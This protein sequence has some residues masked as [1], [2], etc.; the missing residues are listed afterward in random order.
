MEEHKIEKI[1][2]VKD[3]DSSSGSSGSESCSSEDS[4]SQEDIKFDKEVNQTIQIVDKDNKTLVQL[5]PRSI[6]QVQGFYQK[7]IDSKAKK[8]PQTEMEG[9]FESRLRGLEK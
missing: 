7:F 5:K 4:K 9:L 6:N 3:S 8:H 1:E 2:E